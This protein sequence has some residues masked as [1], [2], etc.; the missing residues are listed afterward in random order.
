[1]KWSGQIKNDQ[2]IVILD[3]AFNYLIIKARSY[4]I[5]QCQ[6]NLTYKTTWTT[7]RII[8]FE[9]AR[10]EEHQQDWG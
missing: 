3:P 1:M 10:I 4:I 2:P 9:R 5:N 6:L 7:A 8:L